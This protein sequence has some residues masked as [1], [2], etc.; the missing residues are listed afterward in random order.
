[1]VGEALTEAALAFPGRRMLVLCGHTHCAAEVDVLH[2]LTV[3]ASAA[4]YGT[5]AVQRVLQLR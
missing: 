1:V 2:N 3:L 4:V 5:P